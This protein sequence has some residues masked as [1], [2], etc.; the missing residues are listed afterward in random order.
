[1]SKKRSLAKTI[2]EVSASFPV[3]LVTGPRQVGK[4]TL[5]EA[6]AEKER[7]YVTLDDLAERIIAQQDPALFLQ[8]HPPSLIVDEVQY[9]PELFSYIKMA[10]DKAK[11]PGM[12]W[13][14]GSQRF[15]LMKGIT[16]SLA[17][18]IAIIDM[19][20][21][22]RAE[23][24]NRA[25]Q[26]L[27]FLPTQA[28]VTATKKR[29]PSPRNLMDIYQD[30]WRG[31]YPKLITEP[32]LSRD[33]FYSSYIQTYISRDVKDFAQIGNERAFY[34]FLRA[35]AARTG[36]LLNYHELARDVGIDD[37]TAKNWLSILEASGIIYLLQP[38]Y[39]NITKRLI[40]TPKL[41]FLDTGLC[42]YLTHW[43]TPQA[44]EAG[45]MSGAIL[46]TY[47]FAEILKSY[48]HNGLSPSI[49]FYRDRDQR[50]VDFL[51]EQDQTLYPIE[52]KKTATPS[53]TA[54]K[55]FSALAGLNKKIGHGA[56]VCLVPQ[57]VALSREV[58][59]VPVGYL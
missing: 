59:A 55:Q 30:I 34:I 39:A 37:K 26:A 3:I 40:K 43:S 58:D 53:N 14:T 23:I 5:L 46:E 7:S 18:R 15:H 29:K 52:I 8:M 48:W 2:H 36:Q 22:S 35:A 57:A 9:A 32:E 1:M 45:A 20:G 44:L 27:P 31:S 19:L 38:Y 47:V 21:F 54:T 28:W 50:E 24:E 4:T 49:Y 10:V 6:C 33:I 12:F 11:Q 25:D 56:V 13:L 51:I 17:G 41:Y 16:E 42:A